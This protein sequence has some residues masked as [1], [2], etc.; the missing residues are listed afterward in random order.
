MKSAR[1]ELLID[2]EESRENNLVSKSV[3]F[4]ESDSPEEV[5]IE[6]YV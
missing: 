6:G 4:L 3:Q 5:A 1:V 2:L